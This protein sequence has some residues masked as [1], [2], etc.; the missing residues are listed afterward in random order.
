MIR[1]LRIVDPPGVLLFKVADPVRRYLRFV[2]GRRLPLPLTSCLRR[3]RPDTIRTIVGS[4]VGE[5]GDLVDENE[6]IQP[7]HMQIEDYS[8]PNW[9]P[10]AI[11]AGP[12][13]HFHEFCALSVLILAH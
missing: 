8:D 12:G 3:D 10:E 5:G 1:C 2:L 9:E 11:D 13:L 4:L 7:L 6:P